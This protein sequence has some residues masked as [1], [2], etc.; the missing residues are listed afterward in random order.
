MS[1]SNLYFQSKRSPILRNCC[2]HSTTAACSVYGQEVKLVTFKVVII[3]ILKYNA[4]LKHIDLPFFAIS[5]R[6]FV[7]GSVFKDSDW[8]NDHQALVPSEAADSAVISLL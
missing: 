8:M 3:G 1:S 4:G 6:E 2:A 7:F 5:D